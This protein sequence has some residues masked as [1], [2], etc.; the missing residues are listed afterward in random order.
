MSVLLDIN[1]PETHAE[2]T[3]VFYRYETA[4]VTNDVETLDALFWA[5]DQTIRLGAS[6]NLFGQDEILAF[7]KARPG[8]GLARRLERV[9]ITTFGDNFATTNAVFTRAGWPASRT[10][11]QSQS[12]VKVPATGWQI[13]SAHVSI[14][15]LE[16]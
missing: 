7:R 10:G 5:S 14:V 16:K 8:V 12:L 13:V 1:R 4:L 9:V 3:E 2:V 6:E 11:R 15:D